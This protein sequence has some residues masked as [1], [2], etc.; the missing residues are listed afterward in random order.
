MLAR[1]DHP[2]HGTV[3]PEHFVPQMESAGMAYQLTEAVV[4]RAFAERSAHLAGLGLTLAL[5]FPLDVL[6]NP[7]TL[8]WLEAHR[9]A[10]AMT[11]GEVVIELTES[12]P[13]SAL[14]PE[15][16]IRLGEI[17]RDLRARGY[18]V[19]LDDVSPE[20][21]LHRDTF[22]MGFSMMKLD[23]GVVADSADD[24]EANRFLTTRIAAAQ[25]AGMTVVAEGVKDRETWD[26][27][28]AYGIDQAQGF[29]VARPLPAAAVPVWLEAWHKQTA[30]MQT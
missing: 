2:E 15:Q 22:D 5:N 3:T 8:G 28:V 27:M 12:R 10:A 24:K 29:L 18:G 6:M 16:F 11:T 4:S 20:M 26:R 17:V 19:A 7:A 25:G 21:A 14:A 23:K 13:V 9:T 1:L 30:E